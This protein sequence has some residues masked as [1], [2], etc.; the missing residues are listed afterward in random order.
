MKIQRGPERTLIALVLAAV[1]AAIALSI[2]RHRT[3]EAPPSAPV[4]STASVPAPRAIPAKQF[5]PFDEAKSILDLHRSALPPEL[6]AAP[7]SQ[8]DAA[9]TAWVSRHDR[10]IRA[11]L[12]Q[13]DEDSIVN[14]WFYGTSFT[15]RPRVTASDMA[16]SGGG[17]TAEEIIQGRLD[18]L[19]ESAAVPG[20][21]DR[22]LFVRETLSRHGIDP[23]TNAGKEQAQRYLSEAA[24]R[25][26]TETDRY[27]RAERSTATLND[28][29]KTAAFATM[30]HDRGLSSDTRLPIEFALEQAL[31]DVKAKGKMAPGSVRRVAIVGP[32]LDFS[33]KAEGYDFYPQQ[34]IQPFALI[35]SL[36]RL[37]LAAPD[38]LRVTTLD[39]SPR[40]NQHLAAALERARRGEPYVLQ[41]PL[42]D[43]EPARQWQPDLISYW[44]KF[45]DRIGEEVAAIPVPASAGNVR[46][47]AVRVR[48]GVVLSMTPQDLNIVLERLELAAAE[49]F[50]VIVATNILVYYSAFEQALALSN[51]SAMLRPGGYFVT[52]F[53]VSPSAPMEPSASLVTKV[54]HSRQH[55]GDTLFWYQRR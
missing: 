53:A 47:R 39:L 22:L 40:V 6:A 55:A 33:D 10:E 24:V 4:G 23:A 45:G 25:M 9:W 26:A 27:H 3:R 42:A 46:L 32:G 44:Q 50:D 31:A 43:D 51:A 2:A 15:K 14:L 13:G 5:I 11:R 28:A 34:T 52:N 18:D 49:R 36:T 41:L 29:Q 38:D 37:G 16:R 19:I 7:P 20:A 35:D 54:E 21:N 48:P 12:E 8:L 1:I 30:F 17:A